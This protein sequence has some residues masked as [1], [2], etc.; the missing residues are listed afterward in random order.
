[1]Y[2]RDEDRGFIMKPEEFLLGQ[3]CY[4]MKELE[5]AVANNVDAFDNLLPEDIDAHRIKMWG[6]DANYRE[7]WNA[8]KKEK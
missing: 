1:V 3:V 4:S 6:K 7:I 5:D 8:I 2:Y